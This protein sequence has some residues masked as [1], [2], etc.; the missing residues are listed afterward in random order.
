[1]EKMITTEEKHKRGFRIEATRTT[2]TSKIIEIA[3]IK[4]ENVDQTILWQWP[5]N[6]RSLPNLEDMM[7]LKTYVAH[8]TLVGGTPSE[9]AILSK[10]DTQ[11]KIVRKT[12]RRT[13]RKEKKTT[14]RTKDSKN[15]GER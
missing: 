5:T 3:D 8:C 10:I 11:E 15:L 6:Q 14:T 9:I 2:R 12:P 4:K 1:M 7:T 13:I